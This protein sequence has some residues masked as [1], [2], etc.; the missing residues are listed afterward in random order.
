[1]KTLILAALLLV[2]TGAAQADSIWDYTG[3]VMNGVDGPNQFTGCACSLSGS[4]TLDADR[5][6]LAYSFTDG[7]H[8]LDS[9]DSTIQLLTYN[10]ADPFHHWDLDILGASIEFFSEFDSIREYAVDRVSVNGVTFGIEAGNPGSWVDPPVSTPE[11]DADV[12]LI[13][14]LASLGVMLFFPFEKMPTYWNRRKLYWR[15]LK[16]SA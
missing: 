5:N 1:M 4:V 3:T 16:R 2:S 8:S 6:V 9:S 15:E 10:A 14:G 13:F 7:L 11:P 12:Q